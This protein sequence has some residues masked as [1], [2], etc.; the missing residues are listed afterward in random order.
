VLTVL[1]FSTS[2][3]YE[4]RFEEQIKAVQ[5]EGMTVYE[6]YRNGELVGYAFRASGGGFQGIVDLVA[7]VTP[8]LKQLL[9][10]EILETGDTPGLGGRILEPQFKEQ[11]KGL[12]TEPEIDFVKY[13]KP[14]KPNEFEAITGATFTSTA[15]RDILNENIARL[16]EV[17]GE[18]G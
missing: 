9:G 8:D 15:V 3:D 4:R 14:E 12:A 17:L 6:G 2:G 13:V 16:R 18:G 7:G 11:F 5:S 1:G 10:I